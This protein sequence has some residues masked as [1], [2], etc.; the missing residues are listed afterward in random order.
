[1][2]IKPLYQYGMTIN[3]FRVAT[4]EISL[5]ISSRGYLQIIKIYTFKQTN[6]SAV[7]VMSVAF[8]ISGSISSV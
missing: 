7:E 2:H 8:Y 1:M 6:H 4:K 3:R 5:L